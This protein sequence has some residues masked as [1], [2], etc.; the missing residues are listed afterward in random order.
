MMRLHE[1]RPSFML[2]H[3]FTR[4]RLA[5]YLDG[6]LEPG[7]RGRV[8]RHAELCPKCRHIVETL[9][10]TLEGI[11]GLHEEPALA[12]GLADAVIARLRDED[13]R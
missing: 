4:R 13:R 5:D 3:R 2:D 9:L 11:R 1:L 7:G 8:E 10:R 12:H 6:Q